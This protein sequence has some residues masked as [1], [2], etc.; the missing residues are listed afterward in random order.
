MLMSALMH[1]YRAPKAIRSKAM[2]NALKVKASHM[3]Q[4]T[5]PETVAC[6]QDG[7]VKFTND[8]VDGAPIL[9]LERAKVMFNSVQC[10]DESA[11]SKSLLLVNAQKTRD[12]VLERIEEESAE[13]LSNLHLRFGSIKWLTRLCSNF[14]AVHEHLCRERSDSFPQIDICRG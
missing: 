8:I 5:T 12:F 9:N 10:S 7:Q 13:G 3:K 14:V 4:T 11:N 1:D 6:V 2:V